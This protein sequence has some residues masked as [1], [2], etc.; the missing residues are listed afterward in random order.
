[1]VLFLL[2]K[3][4]L[5]EAIEAARVAKMSVWVNAGLIERAEVSQLRA[6]GLDLTVMTR[7]IDPWDPAEVE[8]VVST[9]REHHADR[10]LCVEWPPA[11]VDVPA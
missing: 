4:G 9:I 6:G 3:E 11:S 10:M 5:A 1:M 2:T 8:D 7:R